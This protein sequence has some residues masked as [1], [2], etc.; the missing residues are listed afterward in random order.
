MKQCL[1]LDME[2]ADNPEFN[3]NEVVAYARLADRLKSSRRRSNFYD[4]K[5]ND[6]YVIFT[7]DEMADKLHVSRRTVSKIYA[8]LKRLGLI[9]VKQQFN[10]AGKIFLPKVAKSATPEVQNVQPNQDYINQYKGNRTVNT[11]KVARFHCEDKAEQWIHSTSRIGITE[12]TLQLI[13]KFA[14]RNLK[15]CRKIVRVILNARNKVAIKAKIA[16]TAVTQFESNQNLQ[17]GLNEHLNHIFSYISDH[18]YQKYWGY[19]TNALKDFF[20]DAFG[21]KQ[22]VKVVKP[23][24]Q[25]VEFNKRPVIHETLPDWANDNYE[26][27]YK[28]A[29][30][31]ERL[32]VKEKLAKL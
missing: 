29:P 9:V 20:L 32:A 8:H 24:R 25:R 4:T 30:L 1:I 17:S 13:L 5:M 22:P 21:L 28:Q 6:Y 11:A 16:K 19:L 3:M 15:N 31:A 27:H 2:M 7:L 23:N 12:P 26:P 10:H 18:G 14:G